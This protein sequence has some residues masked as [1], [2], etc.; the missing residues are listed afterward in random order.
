MT[1]QLQNS[2]SWLT[3][4]SEQGAKG[5][6]ACCCLQAHSLD[7]QTHPTMSGSGLQLFG[8]RSFK[9]TLEPWTLQKHL[10]TSSSSFVLQVFLLSQQ[11]GLRACCNFWDSLR[12]QTSHRRSRTRTPRQRSR[13]PRKPRRGNAR[14]QRVVCDG[15]D[16]WFQ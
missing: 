15:A 9:L 11:L 10:S 2:K 14:S 8:P 16:G 5:S 12:L 6:G 7:V 1:T 4:P 13:R 3:S